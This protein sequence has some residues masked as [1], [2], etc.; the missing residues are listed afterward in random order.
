M[1]TLDDIATYDSPA[2]SG[3]PD[4]ER[5]GVEENDGAL[6]GAGASDG[7]QLDT[8]HEDL[9]A[10]LAALERDAN[11]QVVR[12]LGSG[13]DGTVT[14]LVQFMGANG[15]SFG[16]F[17]RKRI[18][19]DAGVGTV[20]EDIY[21]AQR[22]GRRFLHIP[23]IVECYKTSL[24]L[25]VVSEYVPG[26]DLDQ[27]LGREGAGEQLALR[28]MPALCDAVAELHESFDPPII[29]R[30]LKPAN[31]I[32]SGDDVTLIDF[33]IARRFRADAGADTVRF[34]TRAYAPPEQY[35]FGQTSVRSDIYALGMVM[36]FCCTGETEQGPFDVDALMVRGLS[37]DAAEIV[38]RACAFDPS[39]RFTSVRALGEALRAAA[40][41][42]AIAAQSPPPLAPLVFASTASGVPRDVNV[43]VQVP[44]RDMLGGADSKLPP[45]SDGRPN[46]ALL[47]VGV[48]RREAFR[49]LGSRVPFALG[50]AWDVL[51]LICAGI[52]VKY[53]FDSTVGPQTGTLLGKP[54]WYVVAINWLLTEPII[55][56]G[57]YLA[58]DRRPLRRLLPGYAKRT[59]V[60]DAKVLGIYL[61]CAFALVVVAMFVLDV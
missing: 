55:L 35:G 50:V 23:R 13:K 22:A 2:N 58:M 32:I 10:F 25:V 57:L 39:A 20:Y 48:N 29:H 31:V 53:G 18:P 5:A 1:K 44:T 21:A 12:R 51:I 59:R 9:E 40:A 34:G 47:D 4:D 27:L 45:V 26:E 54:F 52:A 46:S 56:G 30:D 11:Y 6:T 15:S 24:E 16:P 41:S 19:L 28:V 60:A 42:G 7:V 61:I 8:A 49:S 37:R 38:A 43:A 36:F 17:V 33:G 14:E 3:R